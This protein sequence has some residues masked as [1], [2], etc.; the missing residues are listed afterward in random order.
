MVKLTV[1]AFLKALFIICSL[2]TRK[3]T[4]TKEWV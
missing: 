4:N 3:G 1:V 2:K